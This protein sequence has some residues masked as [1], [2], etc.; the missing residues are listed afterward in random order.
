[1]VATIKHSWK[2]LCEKR[3]GDYIQKIIKNK[4]VYHETN[5]QIIVN[6]DTVG[7]IGCKLYRG[8]KLAKANTGT[9]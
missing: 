3:C 5:Y 7:M 4:T 2:I 6:D 8:Q 9:H 1:M